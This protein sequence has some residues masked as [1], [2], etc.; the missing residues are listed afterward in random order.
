MSM[1]QKRLPLAGSSSSAPPVGGA[2]RV[3]ARP[4]RGSLNL[5]DK[6][7]IP[8]IGKY[9]ENAGG[10]WP[11]MY[12]AEN[13]DQDIAGKLR[14]IRPP[15]AA[16]QEEVGRIGGCHKWFTP[17]TTTRRGRPGVAPH[18]RARATMLSDRSNDGYNIS[19]SGDPRRL[20]PPPHHFCIATVNPPT[21]PPSNHIR[22]AW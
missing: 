6:I 21:R 9:M 16:R 4:C 2:R 22:P 17:S 20:H 8:A 18:K 12:T 1:P 14:A 10:R 3:Y 15:A 13:V 5:L 7:L 19:A 11:L